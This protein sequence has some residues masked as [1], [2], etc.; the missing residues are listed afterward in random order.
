MGKWW[1]IHGTREHGRRSSLQSKTESL[2]M[3]SLRGL[4]DKG[5]KIQRKQLDIWGCS[6]E[7]SLLW[8][9]KFGGNVIETVIEA[10]EEII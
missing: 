4:G 2:D 3:L 1:C 8:K 5:E 9:Q 6:A 7:R 10:M